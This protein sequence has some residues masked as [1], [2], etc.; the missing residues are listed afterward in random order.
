[1]LILLNSLW[2]IFELKYILFWLYLW[3]LK[4]YHI[5]RFIDHFRTHKGK[6]LLFNFIQILKFILLVFLLADSNLFVYIFSILFLIYFVELLIVL[7]NLFAKSLKKPVK[8]LKTI[9]LTLFSFAVL[10]LFLCCTLKLKDKSQLSWLVAF[11]ILT[12]II[13]SAIVLFIQPIFVAIRNKTL[14]QAQSKLEKVKELNGLKVIAITGSYG[15]TSTKEFLLAI[16]S[17]KFKVL[18]TSEHQNAEIGIA[19]CILEDLK[20]QPNGYPEIFIAEVAAYDKGKVKEVC[21]IIKPKI[22]IVTGVNEQHLAVF[23]SLKNLL[24]GEGGRELAED[25]PEDGILIVNGDNKYCLDLYKKTNKNKKLYSLNNKIIN[26]DIWS[27]EITVH[28]KYI[29]FVAVDKSGEIMHFDAKVLGKHNIQNLLGA[30]LIAKELGMSFYE[31]AEA[32]KNISENQGG[33]VLKQGQHGI[34]IIDSSYSANPD[35]V[36]ADLDYLSIFPN[37]KV[38]I[39]PCLIELGD[40]SAEI[41]EKIGKK[42]ASIC[43]LAII[44]SKDKFEEIKIGAMGDGMLEKNILLCEDVQEIYSAITLFCKSGDAILLEGRVPKGLI[45]LLT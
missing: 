9:F 27:S 16:L 37:K 32:C 40:K 25:L 13:I 12:P 29:S 35:G 21:S 17:K 39:M 8:T 42:I 36:F 6:K 2:F 24:S 10:I 19:K 44:T 3:Q 30:I 14:R 34:D 18:S 1:M 31:I 23:G 4:E 26:S 41:H 20:P 22:G 33:M 5:G 45:N 28:K 38:V 15:K 7:K 11:D 43:D